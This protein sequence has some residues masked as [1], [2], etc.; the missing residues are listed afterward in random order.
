LNASFTVWVKRMDVQG[1][2]Y[3]AVKGV[4]AQH[5]VDDFTA[6]WVAQAKLDLDP[7]LVTLRL[8]NSSGEEPTEAEETAAF[9]LRPRLTL[10]DAG[11]T[12]GCSLLAFI[13]G[14]SAA[15]FASPQPAPPAAEDFWLHLPKALVD[16]KVLRLSGGTTFLGS[17]TLPGS[18]YIR[19][20]YL[21]L[22]TEMQ[23]LLSNGWSRIVVSGNP[24]IGKSWFGLYV[25]F[26]LLSESEPP[27]IVWEARRRSSRTLIR[28]GKVLRG[29][30]GS[31]VS[32]LDDTRTWYLVD[33]AVFPGAVEVEAR[34][35]VF[36]S[37]KR[38]NY[39]FTLKST[40]STIRFLPVWSWEEIETC[41]Q[42]LYANDPIRTPEAVEEAFM[43][44][45][46]IPRYVLEKTGDEGANS[47]LA[48]AISG[49]D[50]RLVLNSVGQIDTAPETSHRVLHIS[51]C[52][53][54]YLKTGVGF[55]SDFIRLCVTKLLLSRQRS[56]LAYFACHDDN[57]LFA[58]L[59]GDCFEAYA[60]DALAAGG[61]FQVRELAP[62]GGVKTLSLSQATV[63]RFS[64]NK[65]GDLAVL[66]SF[67]VG[68][69]CQPLV[70]NFP[71]IDAVILPSTLLQM[72]VSLQHDVKEDIMLE[73]LDALSLKTAELVFVVPPDKFYDF[74]APTFKDESLRQRV[75]QKALCVSFDIVL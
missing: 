56:E 75:T 17:S 34:T 25:A 13:A 65:P 71:V 23:R 21:G 54:K 8:V 68:D 12:D 57:P 37:P 55:G 41:R 35:L 51:T 5:S 19:D 28:G 47:E 59:R 63:R 24:G 39:R 66:R 22:W 70:G 26:R 52:S 40:A 1:A 7:S 31:F 44:W 29:D 73:I 43:R 27:T 9:V 18:M 20:D 72:T 2:R 38:E 11:V 6:R 61:A 69:Y 53:P 15:S 4:D 46:G 64:G 3:V 74:K 16:G 33:E 58:K 49:S 36:S 62:A 30:L 48:E 60:H 50:L 42:L 67:L 14:V 10:A 32:E 45:G